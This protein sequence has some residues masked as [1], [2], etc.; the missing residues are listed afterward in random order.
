MRVIF[1]NIWNGWKKFAHAVGRINTEIIIF[2]FYYLIFTPF[3]LITK[4]FGFDP[5]CKKLKGN[6]NWREIEI[7]EFDPEKASH[8][9]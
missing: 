7:G 2:L 5:L 1:R 6:S 4:L 8:Q 3:G 9:S